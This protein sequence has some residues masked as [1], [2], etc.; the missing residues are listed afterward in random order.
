M[1]N[2]GWQE[3][4]RAKRKDFT[5]ALT[6]P[7]GKQVLKELN[8]MFVNR[9]LMGENPEATAYNVG[10]RDLVQFINDLVE[11]GQ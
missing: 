2:T 8:V 7:V 10:Q 9:P 5:A 11:V 3:A 6:T 1:S 4:M